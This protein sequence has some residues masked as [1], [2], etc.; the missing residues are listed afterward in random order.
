M[1]VKLAVLLLMIS[2]FAFA[3]QRVVVVE[4]FTRTG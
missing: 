2:S 1:N 3:S 4:E